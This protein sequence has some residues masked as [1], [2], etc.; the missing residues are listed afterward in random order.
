MGT[1]RYMAPEYAWGERTDQRTDVYALGC[2][3]F[4]MLNGHPPY[5]G[6]HAAEIIMRHARDPIP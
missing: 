5:D 1:P 6:Y 4:E 2:I 3:L